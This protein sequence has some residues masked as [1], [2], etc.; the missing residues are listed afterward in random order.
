MKKIFAAF[1]ALMLVLSL[2]GCGNNATV[3]SSDDEKGKTNINITDENND[4]TKNIITLEDDKG[5]EP[6]IS[7]LS[8]KNTPSDSSAL[9]KYRNEVSKRIEDEE[10]FTEEEEKFFESQGYHKRNEMCY[11][12]YDSLYDEIYIYVCPI[13]Y[14]NSS[15]GVEMLYT[16]SDG[17]LCRRSITGSY[18]SDYLENVHY[19][20]EDGEIINGT[21]G[22]SI[23]YESKTGRVSVWSLGE[24]VREYVVPEESVYTGL[25]AWAGYI[26]RSG[27]DVYAVKDWGLAGNSTDFGV[28]PIAHNVKE[29]I[30]ADYYLSSDEWSNPLFLMTDGTLKA[31]S[32]WRGDREAP[33]DD[34]SH[35]VD[36][37]YEG[38]YGK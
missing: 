18:V 34:E 3:G 37:Y 32:E 4:E 28:N 14:R 26:F 30:L 25:S 2:V 36:I 6:E 20:L 13:L 17:S 8:F 38:G 35:L 29:V 15:G 23:V 10:F 1:M 22:Y 19:S 7:K 5:V 11:S 12:K 21:E 16:Y 27:T 9:E 24:C 31:Y 33:L